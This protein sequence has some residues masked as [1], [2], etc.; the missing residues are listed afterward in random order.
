MG[1]GSSRIGRADP[2]TSAAS[3]A[4]SAR[5]F[6]LSDASDLRSDLVDDTL[7][8]RPVDKARQPA[9]QTPRQD[10]IT[11]PRGRGRWLRGR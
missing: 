2:A 1:L 9:L 8:K 3:A 11:I 7:R 6:D 10:A 5:R 4:E